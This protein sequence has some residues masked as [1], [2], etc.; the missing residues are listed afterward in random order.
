MW[1]SSPALQAALGARAAAASMQVST[2]RW[3]QIY[4]AGKQR[5][6]SA[7]RIPMSPAL[8]TCIH[9]QH[10]CQV[11]ELDANFDGRPDVIHFKV[12]LASSTNIYLVKLLLQFNYTL[13]VSRDDACACGCCS[14]LVN[15]M[16]ATGQPVNTLPRHQLTALAT[17][18]A[19]ERGAYQDE[20]ACVR[21]G[22]LATTRR[23]LQH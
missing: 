5:A 2:Q 19:T 10:N 4:V 21:R 16:H 1:A 15:C 6:V 22:F 8:P 20:R 18:T 14:G 11:G 9:H 12:Q 23:R 17:K 7:I 13:Q 3:C